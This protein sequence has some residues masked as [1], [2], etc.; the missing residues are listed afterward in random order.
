MAY[1]DQLT[2]FAVHSIYDACGFADSTRFD[3]HLCAII[4]IDDC[5]LW[6]YQLA[7][8]AS[9]GLREF[10]TSFFFD[11]I[12]AEEVFDVLSPAKCHDGFLFVD[13]LST[14]LKTSTKWRDFFLAS[15]AALSYCIF[16]VI[17]YL[18][19]ALNIYQILLKVRFLETFNTHDRNPAIQIATFTTSSTRDIFY[20]WSIFWLRDLSILMGIRDREICNGTTGYFCT[21]AIRG[22][23]LF[24]TLSI[25]GH[26][27]F[28]CGI[29]TGPKIILK[30]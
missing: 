7:Q 12:S 2:F 26:Q 16:C 8:P 4:F 23:W 22:H 21:S 25:R 9:F 14:D 10:W 30:Y 20:H 15:F 5:V 6:T 11:I 18:Q 17:K 28:Q 27:L 1:V 19:N 13:V 24:W 29:S 3:L